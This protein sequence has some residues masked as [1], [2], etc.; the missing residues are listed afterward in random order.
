VADFVLHLM[1]QDTGPF[2]GPISM[3]LLTRWSIVAA[4]CGLTSQ[5]IRLTRSPGYR[6]VDEATPILAQG[7]TRDHRSY[8][9]P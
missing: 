8:F 6:T 1:P 4:F 3:V 7:T 5:A 2:L 9:E